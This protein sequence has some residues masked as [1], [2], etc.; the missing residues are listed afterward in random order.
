M[1]ERKNIVGF[2]KFS[3]IKEDKSKLKEVNPSMDVTPDTDSDLPMNPN[4][5]DL[6]EQMKYQEKLIDI[7]LRYFKMGTLL[8]SESYDVNLN[9]FETEKSE[10][11]NLDEEIEEGE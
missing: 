10:S 8:N 5:P 3:D 6:E 2:K 1:A 7:Y 4:L 11:E 9:D